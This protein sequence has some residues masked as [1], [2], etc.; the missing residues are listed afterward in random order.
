MFSVNYLTVLVFVGFV[1]VHIL[2]SSRCL[3]KDANILRCRTVILL[4]VSYG[5]ETWFRTLRDGR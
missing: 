4:V 5:C 2:S 1:S 3:L